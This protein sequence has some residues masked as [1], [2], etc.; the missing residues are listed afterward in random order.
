M[1]IKIKVK[2]NSNKQEIIKDE[3]GYIVYLKSVPKDNKANTE[4]IKILKKYFKKNVEIKS[5][6]KSK[7]KVVEII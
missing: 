6:L 4:L 3:I 7:N 5:G 2:P 1:I